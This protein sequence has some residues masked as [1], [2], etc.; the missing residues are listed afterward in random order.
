MGQLRFASQ[1]RKQCAV[2]NHGLPEIFGVCES[3][4]MAYGNVVAGSIMFNNEGMVDGNVG[5]PLFEVRNRISAS[6]HY[7]LNEL[8]GLG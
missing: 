4:R 8:I 3:L 1:F 5:G 6:S 7:G 2:V